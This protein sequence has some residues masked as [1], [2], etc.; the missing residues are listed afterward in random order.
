M[1]SKT[2]FTCQSCGY[3]A[4]KWLGRCPDCN[5]W[6]SFAE[7]NYAEPS[8]AAGLG[9]SYEREPVL[10]NKVGSI[11][12]K[13]INTNLSEL[14]RVLGGGIVPGSVTLLAGD[15][16]IGK[17]TF[18]LQ[19][20]YR[21]TQAAHKVL[22]ISAEESL[23]QVKLRAE[24]LISGQGKKPPALA[25]DNF[26]LVNQTDLALMAEAIKKTAPAFVVID[27]I[28]MINSASLTSAN[29]SVS[30]VRECAS[31]L[32]GLAKYLNIAMFIVGHVTKDG[33]IAGPRVLEHI[34][35]TVLYFEGERYSA[36]K[37]LR[38]VKNRFGS[39]NEMGVFEMGSAG[40]KEVL[41]PSQI[42]LA[43]RPK[44][45][46][47]S[48]VV[49]TVQGVRP[50]LVEIQALVSKC[51]FGFAQR[52]AEG[53]D[54]N[55]LALL[56]AVLEKRIGLNLGMED[57]FINVAGGMKLDDPAC[58]LGVVIAIAS[59][60]KNVALASDIVAL[61]EVGL[62]GEVRSVSYLELRVKEAEKLGFKRCIVP[63]ANF[64]E[65]AFKNNAIA[66]LPAAT[67]KEALDACFA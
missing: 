38:V 14:D 2:I 26:Y 44:E 4:P 57:I 42:F 3:Q 64:K 6:N 25:G 49:C 65:Q 48:I 22:Y 32:A 13:R 53:I 8:K 46:S 16:G 30:Q 34:V 36:Y 40:L 1:K 23:E 20:A 18:C 47:G 58:D 35:D 21:L 60:F 55:R 7:E 63:K 37:I 66:Y 28:Q 50:F 19:I 56:V 59:S 29:G 52:R 51:N 15:P 54:Y 62:A 33:S 45:V 11:A 61:G 17:S 10:L 24:R 39:A 41:N 67:I 31:A 27:S 12:D 5:T 43:E 9:V